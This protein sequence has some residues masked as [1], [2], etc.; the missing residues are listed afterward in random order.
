MIYCYNSSIED[1]IL[2][3]NIFGMLIDFGN[4]VTISNNTILNTERL[5]LRIRGLFGSVIDS[6]YI[7]N[8]DWQV[9]FFSIQET[10]ISN[11]TIISTGGVEVDECASVI[12]DDI[13]IANSDGNGLFVSSS[14]EIVIRDCEISQNART[15]ITVQSTSH[16]DIINNT[17]SNNS[18][19]GISMIYSSVNNVIQNSV[20]SNGVG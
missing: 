3:D 19:L 17:V 16:C 5:P 2:H 14:D 18:D 13:H 11:C 20:I 15:G 7:S 6:L 12:V 8:A 9:E 1:N 4:N 10:T